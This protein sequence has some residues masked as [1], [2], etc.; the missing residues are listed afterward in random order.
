MREHNESCIRADG[1]ETEIIIR[2]TY[3]GHIRTLTVEENGQLY[4]QQST[5]D[6]CLHN[7]TET[8][9]D[10]FIQ[11]FPSPHFSFHNY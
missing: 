5:H 9:L 2:E 3:K 8:F 6:G 10:K 4:Y 1:Y 7:G 11:S